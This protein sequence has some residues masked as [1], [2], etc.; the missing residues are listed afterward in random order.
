[1]TNT[2]GK[3][4]S[5]IGIDAGGTLIAMAVGLLVVPFFF[6]FISKEQYGLW[7]A[8]SGLVALI[9]VLDMGTDQYLTT[10]IADDNKFH[11]PEIG[12]HILST[13]VVKLAITCVFIGI[14]LVLYLFL[15]SLLVIEP[16]T[17]GAAKDAYLYAIVALLIT[18]YAGTISTIL[19]GRHHFS[20][21]SGMASLSSILGS[22]GV[23]VF[24]YFDF[25]ISAFPLALIVAALFQYLV[26]LV[27]LLI[28][29]PH[30]RFR[31]TDFKFQNKKEMISYSVSFQMLRW[32]HTLRTQYIVIA[33]NNLVGPNAAALYNLTNRVPQLISLFASKI[34]LPFFPLLSEHF[35]NNRIDLAADIFIK[36]N[37]L[38]FRF[39]L[40]AAIVCYVVAKA[41]VAAWVGPDSF[42]GMAV[43]FVLTLY[44][45]VIAAM[46]AFGIV[47]YSSKK[48]EK[49][50]LV[51]ITEIICS[52][53]LSYVLSFDH[54]LLGV[55]VGFALASMINQIYLF[56]IVLKQLNIA[57][58]DF[59]KNILAYAFVKN[60]GTLFVAV[61][62]LATIKISGWLDIFLTCI[63]FAIFHFISNE[64]LK[65]LSSNE[66]GWKAK[67]MSAIKL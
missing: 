65:M 61:C 31:L 22:V 60:I 59:A 55:V 36:V 21:V 43:L 42:A 16:A 5:G 33:V 9:S 47:I 37:K 44:A 40:F 54:G 6:S 12:Q 62:M 63:A 28:N 11:S 2:K 64:G 53:V 67:F 24:L 46:G 39:S 57:R 4:I 49:W 56:T 7:L 1:M 14:G 26:L 45:F 13:L 32:F 50:S 48:F 52:V 41:F 38:L 3:I 17:L 51:S 25:N 29:Y 18:L 27:F 66:I 19:Y 8:V 34:A 35:A 20:L 30:I 10:I 23:I 58:K 15:T